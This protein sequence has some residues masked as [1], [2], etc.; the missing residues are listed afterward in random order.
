M[1]RNTH[2]DRVELAEVGT[3]YWLKGLSRNCSQGFLKAVTQGSSPVSWS[4]L[5]SHKC[6]QWFLLWD[7][8]L[9]V[10]SNWGN[11]DSARLRKKVKLLSR[12]WLFATPW[13]ITH[14][15]P[16]SM[17]FSRQ[18]YWSGLPFP[19]PGDLLDPGI[20]PRS[21]NL[22]A[23]SLPLSHLGNPQISLG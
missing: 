4:V 9:V 18:E 10:I 1:K 22:Q 7:V 5:L 16:P 15:V 6:A 8:T 20:K 3:E 21:P 12:V 19:S 14:Q 11:V 17:E 2:N 13:T 23:D